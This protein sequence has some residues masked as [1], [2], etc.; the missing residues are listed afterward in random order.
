MKRLSTISLYFLFIA[1]AQANVEGDYQLISGPKLCPIG[2][3]SLKA[4]PKEKDR[5]LI[6]GSSLAW[7]LTSGDKATTKEVVEGG[8]SYTTTYEK[9]ADKF[10]VKT[11]RSR[12]PNNEENG[13]ITELVEA[14]AQK[15]NYQYEFISSTNKKTSYKCTYNRK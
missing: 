7:D 15:M 12:C 4:N 8:C 9:T 13:V 11:E 14:Q 1:F 5:L 2:S 10:S 6:F 3:I